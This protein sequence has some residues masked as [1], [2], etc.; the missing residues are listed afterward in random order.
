ID[1]VTLPG[2][3]WTWSKSDGYRSLLTGKKALLICA[4]ANRHAETGEGAS[5]FLQP[6]LRH[7]LKFIGIHNIQE[8]LVT[9]TL[10]DPQDVMRTRESAIAT[11]R[12]MATAF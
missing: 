12:A 10:A 11:A 9:P 2:E 1:V 3:N 6:H 4:S 5:D 8:I 7:W